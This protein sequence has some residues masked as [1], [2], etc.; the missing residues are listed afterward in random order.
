MKYFQNKKK[1][2][3]KKI[4]KYFIELKKNKNKIVKNKKV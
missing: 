4:E 1:L 2:V 3:E